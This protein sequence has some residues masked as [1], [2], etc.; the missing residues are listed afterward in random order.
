V[1]GRWP[2][3]QQ[4]GLRWRRE[5]WAG[6]I[7]SA[8]AAAAGFAWIGGWSRPLGVFEPVVGLLGLVGL[9]WCLCWIFSAHWQN[10]RELRTLRRQWQDQD[11]AAGMMEG[12]PND[13][14]HSNRTG[15]ES[16][17]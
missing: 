15:D 12:E 2:V 5:E 4:P 3:D 8:V 16:R 17:P 11:A 13:G 14:P 6:F 9:G 7:A 10:V 1:I